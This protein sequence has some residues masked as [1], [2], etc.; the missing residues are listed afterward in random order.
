MRERV[1]ALR[2]GW[3]AALLTTAVL[4]VVAVVVADFVTPP[5]KVF[6]WL[7]LLA[8]VLAA[9]LLRPWA[10]AVVGLVA[11]ILVWVMSS[12]GGMSG[13]VDQAMRLGAIVGITLLSAG[14]AHRL[15]VLERRAHRGAEQESTLAAIV[16][17][18]ED[19]VITTDLDG[20]I[21]TW[22]D[23][24]TR[25]YGWRADE[26]IGRCIALVYTHDQIFVM[27]D[28]L[29][30]LSA[31][32][33]RGPIEAHRVRKD[34]SHVEVLV[35]M[36]PVRD[37]FGQ[38]VS[39]ARIE[40]DLTAVKQAEEQRRLVIERSALAERLECLGQL[41]GGVAHDFNNLLAI[42]LNYLDFVLERTADAETREDLTRARTSAERARELTRQLLLFAR[43]EP[44]DAEVIDVDSVI[45]DARALLGRTIGGHVELIARRSPEPLAVRC[46][47]G[48]MEQVL[49]NLVI[50]ARDAMPDGGTVVIEAG[51]VR[52]EH[53]PDRL[54]PLPAGPYAQLKVSDT[55]TGMPPEVAARIFEPFFTTK[56]EQHGTGLG[57]ATV[58]SIVTEAGGDITVSSEPGV[59]TTFRILLPAVSAPVA[60]AGGAAG[61][62]RRGETAPGGGRSRILVVEDDAEVRRIA[63]RIL[64]GAGYR[65]TEAANGRVAL[66]RINR[67]PFDLLL[68]DIVMPEMSGSRLAETVLLHHPGTR[69]VLISGYSEE[70]T[71]VR[72]LTVE[73]IEMI[74]KPFT[75]DELL[76]AVR[77]VLGVATDRG[78]AAAGAPKTTGT[79]GE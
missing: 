29:A 79:P 17:S 30:G 72:H 70:C 14:F 76:G 66:D 40:R 25:Q 28:T 64:A 42:N 47:W 6:F 58:Y 77:R 33:R 46:D 67:G 69:I 2:S 36:W 52:L 7:I 8:P 62:A 53:D 32:K 19:A 23:G 63:V 60:R 45:E 34:G 56:A 54:P 68:T 18:S 73:G 9:I 15:G 75:A 4:L 50:N 10:V 20:T 57:L 5:D 31:G 74:H 39:V 37:R 43:Q 24:A 11:L 12:R 78:Q 1:A 65:V 49:L 21:T 38:V 16:R 55:G 48:R 22:N 71:R 13:T 44:G 59:G 51:P 35:S 27:P 61:R 26:A 41:A 3:G